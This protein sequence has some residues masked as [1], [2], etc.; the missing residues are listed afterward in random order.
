MEKSKQVEYL[1]PE[2]NQYIKCTIYD[3]YSL[4]IFMIKFLD[5]VTKQPA[6]RMA[7]KKELRIS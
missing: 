5:P 3:K 7:F 2:T 4:D 6:L 1:H